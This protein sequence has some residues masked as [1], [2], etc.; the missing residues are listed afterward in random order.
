MSEMIKKINW[1]AV[2][3]VM[4]LL[5]TGANAVWTVSAFASR[6]D[7]ANENLAIV[8]TQISALDTR[9]A[10]HATRIS[11]IE[12][13]IFYIRESLQRIERAVTERK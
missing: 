3:L 11:V 10:D 6:G 1:T 5:V 8:K 4:T 7:A 13:H 2:G 12:N 9:S